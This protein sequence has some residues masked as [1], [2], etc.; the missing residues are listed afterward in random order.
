MRT[1]NVDVNKKKMDINKI[2]INKYNEVKN[3]KDKMELW[4]QEPQKKYEIYKVCEGKEKLYL[5]NTKYLPE[6]ENK[7]LY[8]DK[9]IALEIYENMVKLEENVT[10]S[11]PELMELYENE[12]YEIQ[13]KIEELK[14]KDEKKYQEDLNNY[15]LIYNSEIFKIMK[16][17]IESI[18]EE[19]TKLKEEI[20][21]ANN[22][23]ND[24]L[25]KL[26]ISLNRVEEL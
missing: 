19:N 4:E 1:I 26:R 17:N 8:Y 13:R 5:I 22:V 16:K 12:R 9:K 7:E 6:A 3:E 18:Q 24:L 23:I 14:V 10:N 11:F 15:R 25:K 21:H 2:C 20:N